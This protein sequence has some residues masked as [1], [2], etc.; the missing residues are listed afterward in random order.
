[1]SGEKRSGGGPRGWILPAFVVCAA[2]LLLVG[3]AQ[4]GALK[5]APLK[6]TGWAGLAGMVAGLAVCIGASI[7]VKR[8]GDTRLQL[9]RLAGVLACGIG[10]IMVI[11]L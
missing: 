11:C 10:A 5:P 4:R 2:A 3:S 9:L 8:K 7:A 1:M 6:P